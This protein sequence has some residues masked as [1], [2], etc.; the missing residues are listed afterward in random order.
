MFKPLRPQNSPNFLSSL[1]L[2]SHIRVP[3]LATLHPDLCQTFSLHLYFCSNFIQIS[4]VTCILWILF[5]QQHP[6]YSPSEEVKT[7]LYFASWT[8]HHFI[9]IYIHQIR[10]VTQL[11]PTLCDPMNRS[12][13]GLPVHHHIHIYIYIYIS[14]HICV[15]IY[16]FVYFQFSLKE[17]NIHEIKTYFI[18]IFLQLHVSSTGIGLSIYKCAINMCGGWLHKMFYNCLCTWASPPVSVCNAGDPGS[19]PGSGRS[20]EKG[21]ATHSSIL[22]LPLWLSW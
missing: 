1:S 18:N 4:K 22:G 21:Y 8:H 17:S 9:Y 14:I 16:S 12:T 19:F 7:S 5:Q 6:E 15:Y 20:L 2:T 11:C 13:P 3:L 10:S